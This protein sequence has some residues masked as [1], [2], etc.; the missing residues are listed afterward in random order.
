MT[1]A[2]APEPMRAAEVH[3]LP[4]VGRQW[5]QQLITNQPVSPCAGTGRSATRGVSHQPD[6]QGAAHGPDLL[7][8]LYEP[9]SSV[10]NLVLDR[11][12][13]DDTGPSPVLT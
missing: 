7:R 12:R 10:L 4:A 5:V 8:L 9:A 3:R 2:G 1:S 11:R 13:V 6:A